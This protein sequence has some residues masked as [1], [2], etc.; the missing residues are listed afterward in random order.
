MGYVK[1]T[2]LVC[3]CVFAYA[4]LCIYV[5]LYVLLTSLLTY[6]SIRL[7]IITITLAK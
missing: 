4:Y 5:R 2:T 7:F 3:V 6:T 1:K